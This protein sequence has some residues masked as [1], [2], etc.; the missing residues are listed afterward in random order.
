MK[1]YDIE[2]RGDSHYLLENGRPIARFNDLA[3][4]QAVR[5]QFIEE[6]AAEFDGGN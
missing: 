3:K 6:L 4:A 1:F 2:P 5:A